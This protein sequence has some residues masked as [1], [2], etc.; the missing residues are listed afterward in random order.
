MTSAM[1]AAA[2][3]AVSARPRVRVPAVV[4]LGGWMLG[5]AVVVALRSSGVPVWDTIWA[6]DGTVFI[7][8]ALDKSLPDA[9]FTP[10]AGYLHVPARLLA[11]VTV[12]FPPERWA[13]VAAVLAVAAA[14]G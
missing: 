3:P 14:G 10:Y 11:A 2:L 1:E 8:G 7:Q 4:A 12:V 13:L 9:L 5:V 6:E